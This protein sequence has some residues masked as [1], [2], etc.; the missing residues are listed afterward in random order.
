MCLFEH[1]IMC[2]F[3]HIVMCLF[4]H[5]IMCLFE[6]I[7]MCLFEHIIMCLFEHILCVYLSTLLCV[8]LSTLLCV[9]AHYYVFIWAHYYV[10]IWAHYYV[11]ISK[12]SDSHVCT[13]LRTY[14][15]G[16]STHYFE[17]C[18]NSY[19]HHEL[20]ARLWRCD[21][22]QN[23]FRCLQNNTTRNIMAVDPISQM[24]FRSV[25]FQ[26]CVFIRLQHTSS[27]RCP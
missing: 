22:R 15:Q 4:E 11:F 20:A 23:T 14:V 3:Y 7:I 24:L 1:I 10:F 26:V 18:G 5:I 16:R 21:V 6:H 12:L 25:Y 8:Y 2:L 13:L 9:W 19:L 17:C 27:V